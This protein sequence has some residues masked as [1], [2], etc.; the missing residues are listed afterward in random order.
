MSTDQK[1]CYKLV[2][3]VKTGHIPPD[4]QDMQCGPLCHARWLTTAQRIVFMWTRHHGLT[5]QNR[6]TLE[7]LVKFCLEYYFKLYFDMKVKHFIVDAPY[8][9]LTSL[10]I[11]RT[12]PKKVR[13]AVTLY[14]RTGAWYSHPECLLL[15]LLASPHPE[16]RE[17]AVQQVLKLR[18]SNEY[19]DTGVRSRITPR[20]NLSATTLIELI[21]WKPDEVQEPSLTCS[22]SKAEIQGF[23]EEPFVPPQFSCHTQSTER[24]VKLVTEAAAAVCGQDARDGYIRARLQHREEMPTFKTKKDICGSF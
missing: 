22:L 6:K 14:V 19:G 17:F 10:R 21:P 9:I 12:Q 2:Q 20:L 24:C 4:L 16:D 8:H 7:L 15:S 3:A 13:D 5:G 1:N 18:G 11:L 23:L